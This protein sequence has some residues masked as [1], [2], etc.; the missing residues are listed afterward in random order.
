MPARAPY[1]AHILSI[2]HQTL[3]AAARRTQGVPLEA[4]EVLKHF[5]AH[6]VP[7]LQARQAQA[8]ALAEPGAKVP[9]TAVLEA[10]CAE[11]VRCEA[12]LKARSRG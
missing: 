5:S 9:R 2:T 11:A 6:G 10:L 8:L 3:S 12:V 7:P 1:L 4:E